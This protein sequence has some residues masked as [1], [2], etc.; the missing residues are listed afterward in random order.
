MLGSL[1]CSLFFFREQLNDDKN[2]KEETNRAELQLVGFSGSLAILFFSL[3]SFLAI[4]YVCLDCKDRQDRDQ[5]LPLS[6]QNRESLCKICISNDINAVFVPCGHSGCCYQ[7]ALSLEAE[8]S[9][10][11]WCGGS[12]LS[13]VKQYQTN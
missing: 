10:C 8:G 1:A 7:C 4:L 13:V 2:R 3:G 11:P 6:K 9:F 5:D 12:V